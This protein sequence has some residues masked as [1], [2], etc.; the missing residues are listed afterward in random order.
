MSSKTECPVCG[1]Y[2]S[3]ITAGILNHGKCPICATSEETILELE[4]VERKKKYY[5]SLKIQDEIVS[6]NTKLTEELIIKREKYNQLR[7]VVWNMYY[8]VNELSKELEDLY[9]KRLKDWE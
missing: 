9:M 1:S 2:S 7:D 3:T 5:R 8:K 6:E 4:E